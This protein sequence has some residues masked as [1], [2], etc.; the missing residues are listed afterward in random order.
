MLGIAVNV[1]TASLVSKSGAAFGSTNTKPEKQ[2]WNGVVWW[3]KRKQLICFYSLHQEW[4]RI[5]STI[6]GTKKNC[7][8]TTKPKKSTLYDISQLTFLPHFFKV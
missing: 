7:H 1:H 2:E 8:P 6:T 4:N 5:V 3:I